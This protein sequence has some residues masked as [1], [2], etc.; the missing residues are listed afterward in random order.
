MNNKND[1]IE[2]KHRNQIN[3]IIKRLHKWKYKYI[4]QLKKGKIKLRKYTDKNKINT[5]R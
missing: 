1:E 5:N 2:N 3:I 4:S